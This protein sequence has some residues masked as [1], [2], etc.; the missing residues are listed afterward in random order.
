MLTLGELIRLVNGAALR[1]ADEAKERVAQSWFTAAL[2][3]TD[4]MP[5]LAEVM[6]TKPAHATP[7][8]LAAMRAAH[9]E[10]IMHMT[11]ED[12]REVV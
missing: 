7:V 4:R 9:H 3:R 12:E 11:R 6:G 5:S 1:R 2:V 10:M 8:E